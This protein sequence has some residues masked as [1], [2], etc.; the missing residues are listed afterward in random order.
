MMN[1]QENSG[2]ASNGWENTL[3]EK[4]KLGKIKK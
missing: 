4:K 3:T 2:I 1:L